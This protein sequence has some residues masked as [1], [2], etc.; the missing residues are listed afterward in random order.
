MLFNLIQR[1]GLMVALGADVV[2]EGE[3][4]AVAPAVLEQLLLGCRH[5]SAMLTNVLL[6]KRKMTFPTKVFVHLIRV[7]S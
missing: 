3:V 1:I 7:A 4:L 6:A 2:G 5:E